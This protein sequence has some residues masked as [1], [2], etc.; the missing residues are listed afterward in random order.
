[1]RS[2]KDDPKDEKYNGVLLAI[3]TF[4][5]PS[6]NFTKSIRLA[7]TPIF[8][9]QGMADV[10]GKPVDVARNELA[11][12]ALKLNYGYVWFR[13]DDVMADPDALVK[14]MGRLTPQQRANP[15]EVGDVII[16]GV[17][18]SKVCPPQPMIYRGGVPGGF[19]DWNYGDL[20]ECDS[21]GM[22]CTLIPTGVFR[23][24]LSDGLDKFQC[25]NER[26]DVNWSVVHPTG[27]EKCPHCEGPIAPIFFKTVR[28]GEGM[29][30]APVEMT[31]DTYFNLL[32]K[33]SGARVYADCGV[34]CQHEDTQ[35]GTMF[36]FHRGLGIP[37][38][39]CDGVVDF[40]PQVQA[41]VEAPKGQKKATPKKNG[42]VKFNIGCG[43]VHKDGFVNIDLNTK[44][45]FR[46]DGRDLRPAIEKYGQADVIE[47]DH[48]LEHI[49]RTAVTVTVRNWLKALKPGGKLTFRVPDAAAAM[50]DF[51]EADKNGTP[52]AE[53]DFKEAVVFGAQRYP[54]DAHLSAITENKM[55]KI[56]RS[57]GTQIESHT[58]EVGRFEGKNQDEIVVEIVKKKATVK[59]PKKAKKE[60]K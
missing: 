49:N 13:D 34:Q 36:Y 54:G 15:R 16:G 8:T 52:R 43:E 18:Y 60:K 21:I 1:M 22:G 46:C 47:S 35:S 50:R 29:D 51:L 40:Y 11:A 23:K 53:Y 19:E 28:G 26:C 56:I 41:G 12:L 20:V 5:F 9:S 37:V 2:L 7:S 44:A 57:C 17:V 4:G 59:P 24:I 6:I 10:Q 25:I 58:M 27:T 32:A 42:K 31:E 14:L 33:D 30:W 48:M 3:P 55:K 39:E 38:W 45:D